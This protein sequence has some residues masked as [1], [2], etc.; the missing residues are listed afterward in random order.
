VFQKLLPMINLENTYGMQFAKFV[1]VRRGIFKTSK[2]R[3]QA[4][5]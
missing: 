4:G 5:P 1:L 2:M 3:N